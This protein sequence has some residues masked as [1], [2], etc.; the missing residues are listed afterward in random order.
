MLQEHKRAHEWNIHKPVPRIVGFE[1]RAVNSPINVLDGNRCS[2]V[3]SV[4]NN[5]S[6]STGPVVRK[7]LLSP[8]NGMLLPDQ[9]NGD[10]LDIGSGVYQSNFRS[11]YDPYNRF[12]F[13]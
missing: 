2:T 8:L 13:N 3:A 1:S 5:P 10:S 6:D 7:R 9:F 12:F 11:G 4:N